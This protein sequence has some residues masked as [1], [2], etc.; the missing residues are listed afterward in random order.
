MLPP[1]IEQKICGFTATAEGAAI[2]FRPDINYCDGL[3][4]GS[5]AAVMRL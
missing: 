3:N 2:P 4:F 5:S 1:G